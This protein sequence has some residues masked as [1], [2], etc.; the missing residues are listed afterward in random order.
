MTVAAK[1][2]VRVDSPITAKFKQDPKLMVTTPPQ[3]PLSGRFSARASIG[4]EVMEQVGN[5][6]KL[7]V[8]IKRNLFWTY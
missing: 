5:E 1:L 8:K 3:P 6:S 7:V 2:K 4:N